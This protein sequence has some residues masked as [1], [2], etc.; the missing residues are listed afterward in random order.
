MQLGYR[1]GPSTHSS[2]SP[3][4][5][6]SHGCPVIAPAQQILLDLFS[7]ESRVLRLFLQGFFSALVFDTKKVVCS[8]VTVLVHS[9]FHS[10]T[11]VRD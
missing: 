2:A 5:Q 4:M 7:P 8:A 9:I 11:V 1:K 10:R 6:T 3:A